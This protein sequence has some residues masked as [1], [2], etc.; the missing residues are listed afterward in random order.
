MN[1]APDHYSFKC[2]NHNFVVFTKANYQRHLLRHNCIEGESG[3]NEMEKV[4]V[5]PS[6]VTRYT[7]KNNNGS[8]TRKCQSFYRIFGKKDMGG[9]KLLLDYWQVVIIYN[10]WSKRWEIA[11]A[12][13]E[14]SSPEYAMINTRL[15]TILYD[16]R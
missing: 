2:F 9:G 8:G 13:I 11:T 7:Q 15:E 3:R 1:E 14:E 12:Y 5:S 4:L 16:N 6:V 10:R